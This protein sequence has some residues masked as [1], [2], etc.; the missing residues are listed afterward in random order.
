MTLEDDVES[1]STAVSEVPVRCVKQWQ[2]IH[3]ALIGMRAEAA[4]SH[5]CDH[6]DRGEIMSA[7]VPGWALLTIKVLKSRIEL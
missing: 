3:R 7:A 5:K 4:R 2:D 6:T 1:E